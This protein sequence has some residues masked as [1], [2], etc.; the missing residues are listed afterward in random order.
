MRSS[1]A[2][3]IRPEVSL[4]RRW[5]MPGRW[6]PPMPGRSGQWARSALTSVLLE[7]PGP[8]MDGHARRLVDDDEV[9]VFEDDAQGDGLRDRQR[10]GGRR[11]GDNKSSRRRGLCRRASCGRRR[12]G[13]RGRR[14]S[15]DGPGRARRRPRGPRACRGAHRLRSAV[16]SM[17][18]VQGPSGFVSFIWPSLKTK[19]PTMMQR[20]TTMEESATLKA[21]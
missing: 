19:K 8:G 10:Q 15:D 20:P 21:G 13:A 18:S 9:L 14:R 16:V 17:V 3:T 5:T 6:T 4:S 1:L 11:D 7:W 2:A 12:P